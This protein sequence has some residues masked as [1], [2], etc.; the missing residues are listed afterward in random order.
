MITPDALI[1]DPDSKVFYILKDETIAICKHRDEL[2]YHKNRASYLSCGRFSAREKKVIFWP[3]PINP[4]KGFQLL[5]EHLFIKE[6]FSYSVASGTIIVKSTTKS[7]NPLDKLDGVRKRS[8]EVM[9]DKGMRIQGADNS[10][11]ENS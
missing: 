2:P 1:S 8:V 9:I 7:R 10:K 4:L 5:V 6:D 3:D 11:K